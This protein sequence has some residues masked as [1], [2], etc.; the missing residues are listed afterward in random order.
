L[1]TLVGSLAGT[2]RAPTFL[3][4]DVGVSVGDG[5]VET[6]GADVGLVVGKRE[7]LVPLPVVPFGVAGDDDAGD[8]VAFVEVLVVFAWLPAQEPLLADA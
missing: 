1:E 8:A 4:G 7:Q 5:G 3:E 6:A 2:H